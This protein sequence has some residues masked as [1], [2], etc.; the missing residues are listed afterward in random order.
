[1][2]IIVHRVEDGEGG[3]E[4]SVCRRRRN[5]FLGYMLSTLLKFIRTCLVSKMKNPPIIDPIDLGHKWV[6]RYQILSDLDKVSYLVCHQTLV[7][8]NR[9]IIWAY[10]IT[11]TEIYPK[12]IYVLYYCWF[13]YFRQ[14]L[15]FAI[16]TRSYYIFINLSKAMTLSDKMRHIMRSPGHKNNFRLDWTFY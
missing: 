2:R 14:S 12:S 10:N 9:L 5:V 16:G 13:R 7:Y 15:R 6:Y 4:K 3:L 1:M 11:L 8:L